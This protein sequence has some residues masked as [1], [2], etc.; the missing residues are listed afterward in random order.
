[1]LNQHKILRVLKLI[2][3]LEQSPSKTVGHLAE[4]LESTDRTVYRYFDL[5]RECGFDLQRDQFNRFFIQND[6]EKGIRFT[7]EE[8]EFLN[9]LVLATGKTNKLKDSILTKI[10][11]GSEIQLVASHLV[12]AKNGKVIER[13]ALAIS[14]RE[15]V[16]LR[17]YQSINSETIGDRLVEPFGF[18]EDYQ[19]V[20]AFEI[21]SNKNK[22][23]NI[24]RI[25]YVD[26]TGKKS[27]NSKHFQNQVPDVFGFSFSGKN[28][29]IDVQL[30]LRDALLLKEQYP[31]AA[32][33]I[34][35]NHQKNNYQLK[36]VVNDLKP[37]ERFLKGIE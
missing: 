9:Q 34:H 21:D 22:T 30:S 27:K 12:N 24:D 31:Q 14:N 7:T 16:I 28:H 8:A 35:Y 15:Q 11:L 19:T 18:T 33:F 37:I 6:G 32:P 23:F 5:L 13:L 1:M 17:K 36:I 26:F 25:A 29:E 10:Y 3:Y 4:I 20:M 2:S